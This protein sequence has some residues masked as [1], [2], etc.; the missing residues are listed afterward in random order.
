MF[1]III[2]S[3]IMGLL[4]TDIFAPSLPQIAHTFN[5]S[6]NTTQLTISL[7]LA[8]FALSQLF[9]GPL[10]D[11][12]GRKSPLVFGNIIFIIGSIICLTA[13]NFIWLCIGRIIQG[14]GVGGGLSLARVILRDCYQGTELAVRSSRVAIFI[15]LAPAVAPFFGGILQQQFGFRGSFV[16]MLVY[17]LVSLTL[18]LTRFQETNKNK[19][20]YLTFHNTLSHYCQILKNGFFIRFAIISGLA[21]STIIICANMLPFLIQNQL[22]LSAVTN[23]WA[24]LVAA[25]GLSFGSVLSS[26]WVARLSPERFIQL[27]LF[28]LIFSGVGLL[29]LESIWGLHL[30][31][32][33]FLIFFATISCGF[34]FPNAL[35]LCFS[36]VRVNIG[37]A[38]AIYGATQTFISM[39]TNLIL[40]TIPTQSLSL[41]GVF[42]GLIG[43]TG[44]LFYYLRQIQPLTEIENV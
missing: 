17:G 20:Y 2:L 8:G 33:I 11:K 42:C 22:K 7:F 4:G 1:I 26:Y 16:F 37:V 12:V 29:L 30:W 15:C 35:A 27:G 36:A 18:I 5:Q 23:G 43:I 6:P 40:N 39:M 3:A 38:G 32:L 44:L 41:L 34:I 9:Y 21:F 24:L 13:S 19:E 25:L 14:I 28:I 10:S 31:P